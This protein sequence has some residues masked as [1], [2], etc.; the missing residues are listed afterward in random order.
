[1]LVPATQSNGMRISSRTSS[2]PMCAPP[3]APP[4]PNT[5]PIFGRAA[6]AGACASAARAQAPAS[7]TASARLRKCFTGLRKRPGDLASEGPADVERWS[8]EAEVELALRVFLLGGQLVL[9]VVVAE[10]GVRMR[11]ERPLGGDRAVQERPVVVADLELQR[12]A[13]T[14]DA[15]VV[16]E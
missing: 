14:G 13:E 11:H 4:P 16:R 5:R 3:R 10:A 15:P 9:V 7:A 6:G 12:L 1:M 8:V 2:T